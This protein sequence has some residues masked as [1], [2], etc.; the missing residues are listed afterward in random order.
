MNFVMLSRGLQAIAKRI[1]ECRSF[2]HKKTDRMKLSQYH[3]A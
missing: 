1:T 3:K 2:T